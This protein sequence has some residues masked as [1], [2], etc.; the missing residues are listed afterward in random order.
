MTKCHRGSTTMVSLNFC[1]SYSTN[2]SCFWS[3]NWPVKSKFSV[4][5]LIV[6]WKISRGVSSALTS[7]FYVIFQ[8]IKTIQDVKIKFLITS[9]I[10]TNG[11]LS[12]SVFHG[13]KYLCIVIKIKNVVYY[14]GKSV[15]STL[16]RISNIGFASLVKRDCTYRKPSLFCSLWWKLLKCRARLPLP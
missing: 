6:H 4:S 13:I 2:N 16:N 5:F 10:T 11:L 1:L 9:N 3:W 15:F 12:T 8:T 7:N 14:A